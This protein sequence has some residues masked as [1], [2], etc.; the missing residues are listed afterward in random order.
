MKLFEKTIN[1]KSLK[2]K[3]EDILKIEKLKFFEIIENNN[4]VVLELKMRLEIGLIDCYVDIREKAN[5]VKIKSITSIR[6]PENKKNEISNYLNIANN[7]LSFG[8][9]EVE[10]INGDIHVVTYFLCEDLEKDLT[11]IFKRNLY[12][13][14]NIMDYYMPGVMDI[15][16]KDIDALTAINNVNN[17]LNYQLN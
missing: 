15:I 7:M 4:Q 11:E 16:Y 8:H 14:F 9:F 10:Y 1:N 12:T 2:D 3:I 13:N 5:L 6:L 17:T